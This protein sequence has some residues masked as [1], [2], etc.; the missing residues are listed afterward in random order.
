MFFR[1][2]SKVLPP[3]KDGYQP[4]PEAGASGWICDRCQASEDQS[5]LVDWPRKCPHCAGRV[6][7]DPRALDHPWRREAL[8]RQARGALQ[9]TRSN[10]DTQ[11][12]AKEESLHL[13]QKVALHEDKDYRQAAKLEHQLIKAQGDVPLW[14]YGRIVMWLVWAQAHQ[15][16]L[17]EGLPRL[18]QR[19][20]ENALNHQDLVLAAYTGEAARMLN[21]SDA[22]CEVERLISQVTQQIE[23]PPTGPE[24]EMVEGVREALGKPR[25]SPKTYTPEQ[26]FTLVLTL[27][28]Q[29]ASEEALS[30]VV[31]LGGP[32]RTLPFDKYAWPIFA[33]R[34]FDPP[35]LGDERPWLRV[36]VLRDS[37][38][39]FEVDGMVYGPMSYSTWPGSSGEWF[40]VGVAREDEARSHALANMASSSIDFLS[41]GACSVPQQL[42]NI[43]DLARERESCEKVLASEIES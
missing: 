27:V 6:G 41:S 4:P 32:N 22:L 30:R 12:D 40:P 18:R 33:F 11:P 26:L 36:L 5:R 17:N 10:G 28:A 16:A 19:A 29:H 24:R 1:K 34:G 7:P 37:Q 21:Q 23:V 43:E 9:Q 31:I 35:V 42:R 3:T 25:T 13:Q 8:L 2:R 15:D 39:A 20:H 38:W 14:R